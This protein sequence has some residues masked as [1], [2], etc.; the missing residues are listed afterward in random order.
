MLYHLDH[1]T[2]PVFSGWNS[3]AETFFSGKRIKM[4]CLGYDILVFKPKTI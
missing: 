4:A 2:E 1:A 3:T